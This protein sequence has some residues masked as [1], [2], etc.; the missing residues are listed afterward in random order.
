MDF[1]TLATET[2]P[3]RILRLVHDVLGGSGGDD[4]VQE[5]FL[6]SNAT[7]TTTSIYN[8]PLLSKAA[9]AEL[10]LLATNFLLYVAM[11]IITVMVAKIYFPEA[12]QRGGTSTSS[13]SYRRRR[14]TLT[15]GQEQDEEEYYGSDAEDDDDDGEGIDG[16][17]YSDGDDVDEL[18]DSDD[19]TNN[20]GGRA[21]ARSSR[22][23][24]GVATGTGTARRFN[25]LE[26]QQASL[27]KAHVIQRLF[28][29]CLMLNITFV[30]WGALQ[31]R[32]NDL[33]YYLLHF[34]KF[35]IV[36]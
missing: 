5:R 15:P 26:F 22:S 19:D 7:S 31:V 27:S 12:L 23:S 4:D 11:V 3:R 33:V 28:F 8:K 24:R 29:C 14:Q 13:F 16:E 25:F 9:E 36:D 35:F 2:D 30:A 6:L 17:A 1:I 21:A 34:F 10:Y 18:L 20:A 32:R